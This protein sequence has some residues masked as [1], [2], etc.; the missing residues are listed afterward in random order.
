[1]EKCVVY[2][3]DSQYA[4]FFCC[5][6]HIDNKKKLAAFIQQKFDVY[7]YN[8]PWNE[9]AFGKDKNVNQEIVAYSKQIIENTDKKERLYNWYT[10]EV[11]NRDLPTGILLCQRENFWWDVGLRKRYRLAS[12]IMIVFLCSLVLVMGLWKNESVAMLL[13]R[14]AF[15]VPMLEWLF[16]TVKTLNKDMERLKELDE[17]VNNDVTKTIDALQDIQKMIF[18]HRKECYTIPNF[19]YQMFK[20][21]D[22][23]AA[24]RV[25]SIEKEN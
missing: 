25:V 5:R 15:I 2:T 21:N 8:I 13:W 16:N 19:I 12:V 1:M 4:V 11:E 24:R 10:P 7:V 22:E 17:I 14:F 3:S 20:D 6:K 23:D 9:R 18:E